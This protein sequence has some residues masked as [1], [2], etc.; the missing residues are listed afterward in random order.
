MSLSLDRRV[1]RLALMM[2]M[3]TADFVH[4]GLHSQFRQGVDESSEAGN[5]RGDKHCEYELSAMWHDL[6]LTSTVGSVREGP[7][8]LRKSH[9][10]RKRV[11]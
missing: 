9:P 11:A 5:I 1:E 3:E 6:C 7:G 4:I 8:K 2:A 10:I